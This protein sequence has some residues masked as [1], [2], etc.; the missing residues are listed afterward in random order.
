M[1]ID[2]GMRKQLA[3]GMRLVASY[4]KASTRRR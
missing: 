2:G 1:A 3:A 4:R